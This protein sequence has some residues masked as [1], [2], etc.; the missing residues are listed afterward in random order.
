MILGQH[1]RDPHDSELD[2]AERIASK[3]ETLQARVKGLFEQ[4]GAMT[5]EE[6]LD[7]YT[8]Q[9][10]TIYKNSLEPRRYELVRDGWL[11]KSLERRPGK[12]GVRRIVWAPAGPKGQLDIWG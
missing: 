7:H 3:V 5:D 4:Y 1:H 9:F 10:G 8:S 12:S 6:L 11:E 2:G